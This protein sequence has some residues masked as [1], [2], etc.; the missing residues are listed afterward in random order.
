MI[1]G[2]FF[3]ASIKSTNFNFLPFLFLEV[4]TFQLMIAYKRNK[5]I[6][7]LFTVQ[8][9]LIATQ[10]PSY[11]ITSLPLQELTLANISEWQNIGLENLTII[12]VCNALVLIYYIVTIKLKPLVL[13]SK[14]LVLIIVSLTIYMFLFEQAPSTKAGKVIRNYVKEQNHAAK[15]TPE[16]IAK[17]NAYFK[18]DWV[19]SKNTSASTYFPEKPKNIIIIFTEGMS[20]GVIS[21]NVTPNIYSLQK[22]SLNVTNYYNHTAATYR[23]LYGQ[24]TSSYMLLGGSV[25][26]AG[27]AELS[28]TKLDEKLRSPII[29]LP[30]ILS[31]YDYNSFFIASNAS[32]DNLS[33]M[34][35]N[36]GFKPIGSNNYKNF[37]PKTETANELTDKQV[38]ELLWQELQ[39]DHSEPFL[40]GVYTVGTHVG[41]NSP[42]QIYQDGSNS[43]LNK[44]YNLDYQIGEFLNKFD[45]SAFKEDTL[46]IFTADHSTF[47]EKEF[48]NTF[49]TTSEVFVDTMPLIIYNG[50]K[51]I[52]TID[53]AGKNSLLLTPTV[54]DILDIQKADN[55]FLGTSLFEKDRASK[56]NYVSALGMD[57]IATPELKKFKVGSDVTDDIQKFYLLTAR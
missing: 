33:L 20:S 29:S 10:I 16:A 15:I 5:I 6:I 3:L 21:Q 51:T 2:L 23:G 4:A 36:I 19:T 40:Y 35:R 45:N 32:T 11:Y 1:V 46:I 54:L 41:L 44:F 24:L 14:S 57:F 49:H 27:L 26:G 34:L 22:R 7:L 50:G 47:P 39:K 55:Y 28:H 48:K 17:A 42:D 38:Y 25:G 8:T 37:V 52:G 18:K 56:F 53:A 31:N 9:V 13:S 30:N 12:F 43:Y